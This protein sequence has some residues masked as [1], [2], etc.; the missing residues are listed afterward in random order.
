MRPLRSFAGFA[1]NPAQDG[2]DEISRRHSRHRAPV[3]RQGRGKLILFA[4]RA[5]ICVLLVIL[6]SP[7]SA[8]LQYSIQ[9][10]D[11]PM[12]AN[13]LSF[14]NTV[15]LG[16]QVRLSERD[17][18]KVVATSMTSAREA[19]R[20]FGY[21][22]PAI[23][24]RITRDQTGGHVLELVIETGPP[25]VVATLQLEVK[26]AGAEATVVRDW[27]SRWPLT[28]GKVLD[29]ILWE[30]HKQSVIDAVEAIGFLDAGFEVHTLEIS[31][32]RHRASVS[33]W[34]Y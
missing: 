24:G 13:I 23:T 22:S 28:E 12:K 32:T 1:E 2:I 31:R 33:S 7:A 6:A 21:Y 11:D 9:G 26:G 18:G 17:Y 15:Q 34:R 4:L 14:V 30:Q 20:P 10:V 19:L 27:K 3:S 29:Q 16:G 5:P 25:V 8:Q